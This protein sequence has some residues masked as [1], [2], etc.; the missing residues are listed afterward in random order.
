MIFGHFDIPALSDIPSLRVDR[1]M[2]G[3]DA[4]RFLHDKNLTW[5]TCPARG[6]PICDSRHL[7]NI[8]ARHP[9]GV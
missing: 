9:D 8:T 4:Q 6:R 7:A 5:L 2:N 1:N 3:L